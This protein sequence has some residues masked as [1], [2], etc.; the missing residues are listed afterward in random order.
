MA[1]KVIEVVGVSKQSFAHA[2]ENAVAEAARTVRGLR[3][4][5][6]TELEMALEGKKVLEYRAT[7]RL[8]FGVER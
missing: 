2:A 5:R 1:Q 8:Y 4:A 3:W 7:A 6:V